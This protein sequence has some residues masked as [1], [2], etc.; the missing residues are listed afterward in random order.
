MG[1]SLGSASLHT[2]EYS[3]ESE[4]VPPFDNKWGLI[5]EGNESLLE[6]GLGLRSN[7]FLKRLASSSLQIGD[8]VLFLIKTS[9]LGPG[10]ASGDNN[11]GCKVYYFI[12]LITTNMSLGSKFV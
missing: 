5:G 12:I 1:H 11:S 3:S 4:N 7:K 10:E 2:G 8:I 6:Q 9:S